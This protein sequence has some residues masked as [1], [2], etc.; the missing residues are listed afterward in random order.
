LSSFIDFFS[1][2]QI[3]KD[4]RDLNSVIYFNVTKFTDIFEKVI[5]FFK[6]YPI[7]GNKSVDFA[8]FTKV[9]LLIK[10][11]VH[12]TEKGLKDISGIKN[13]MNK[14]RVAAEPRSAAGST[15]SFS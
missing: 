9:S 7:I 10:D 14:R 6:E 8:D 12:L 5:P 2:G 11:K 15:S 3:K 1:C 13:S 4:S